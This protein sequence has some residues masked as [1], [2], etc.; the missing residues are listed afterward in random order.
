[1]KLSLKTACILLFVSSALGQNTFVWLEGEQPSSATFPYQTGGWGNQ[2][3]LSE[4][5]AIYAL[6]WNNPHPNKIIA[7]IDV[8][9]E[10]KTGNRYGAPI[11]LGI[12]TGKSHE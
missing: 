4:G 11:V 2:T 7:R 1:M 10:P 3:Y 9:Y 8:R 6:Q 5:A 12:S